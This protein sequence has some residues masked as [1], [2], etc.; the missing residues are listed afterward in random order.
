MKR[1]ESGQLIYS[2]SDLIRFINSPFASWMDRYHLEN[3]LVLTPDPESEDQKL[4]AETGIAHEQ[5][6]LAEFEAGPLPLAKISIESW[7]QA[8]ED[9]LS[10]L[11]Q[12][13]P[14]IYQAALSKDNFSGFADFLVL[15]EDNNYEIWDT[16]LA[17]SPKPYFIIQL[18]CYSE[19]LATTLNTELPKQ[20]GVILGTNER[21]TFRLEDFYYYYCAIKLEF[22]K[23]QDTFDGNIEN[24]P[25]PMPRSDH[26]RW[27]SHAETYFESTDHLVQVAGIS[28]G[29][30]K[31]LRR[32]DIHTMA[33]LATFDGQSI[34]KLAKETL[35]KLVTQA[36]L[37]CQTRDARSTD[38]SIPP[39]FLILEPKGPNGEIVGLGR[40]PAEHPADVYFDMEGYPLEVGGL[41]YLFGAWVTNDGTEPFKD[42]WAH[43]RAEEKQAFEGFIDWVYDRWRQ[44]P[45]MH[46]YH[47]AAYE[48]SAVRRLSTRHDTRQD[49]VDDLLRNN[50]FVDLY[51]IVRKGLMIGEDSYSIK[52]VERL[53]RPKRKTEVANAVDSIVQY[54]RWQASGQEK[55]WTKSEILK[56]I[57]D[58]NE[59]DCK[60]TAELYDWLKNIAHQ[61]GIPIATAKEIA[62]I[63]IPE[64]VTARLELRNSLREYGDELGPVLGD[65]IEF[66]R[67]EDKPKWWKFFDRIETT[68]EELRDDAA[69]IAQIE[70]VGNTTPEKQ[71]LLQSY[72]FDP[73][74]ECKSKAGDKVYFA[75]VPE[76]TF[77]LFSIDASEG[78]LQLKA[79]QRTLDASYGGSFPQFGSLIPYEIVS[80]NPIPTALSEVAS[81]H[82]RGEL[83]SACSSI[84]GRKSSASEFT[85]L[86]HENLVE[87]AKS[88]AKSM[89]GGCFVVQGPPGTGKTFTASHMIIDLVLAGKKVGIAS[90]SHKAILNLMS[91]C[92]ERAKEIS[93][94]LT[95]IKVGGDESDAIFEA[96]PEI[97]Y[98]KDIKAGASA[99]IS[100]I[101]G[102]TAWAFSNELMRD[103]VDYLVIDEAGQV[104][105]ANAVAMSSATENLILLG[106][107]M[108]LEQPIQGSHPGH[109]G[110]SALQYALLDVGRS[111]IDN[112]VFHAVVPIHLGLFL[113]ES[114][115]MHS[116]VC[117]FISDSIYEGQLG[118]HPDCDNQ[119]I[120]IPTGS[121][122]TRPH[123]ITFLPIEHEGNVQKSEEEVEQVLR[124]YDALVGCQYVDKAGKARALGLDDFL[125]ISP[126]NA[127]VR[128]LTDALPMGARVGSVD[129]FQG[130]EAPICIVSMCSSFGEY[131]SRGLKF[132]LDRNRVNVAIS[133]AQCLAIIIG[134][135]RTAYADASSI[136]EMKLINLYS[137]LVLDHSPQSV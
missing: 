29:Q 128:A 9:T 48:V 100:G 31:K 135:P 28:V 68:D 5:A 64:E 93:F 114:R 53:Y 124:V 56:D 115:R 19:M 10:I 107:Q 21:I 109:A 112:P 60:S 125:F 22:L 132:I 6:I 123:G 116:S 121:I 40:L 43:D 103:S 71:S 38:P 77:E 80:A 55:L 108:Q 8:S 50:V 65:L 87:K 91:A 86:V 54:A 49:E 58:Y 119:G 133:R 46:I 14:V 81:G 90:N 79:T 32:A 45:G 73:S 82:L 35:A 106:D 118:A 25:E 30:I 44:N 105:L 34:P 33:E 13:V 1:L 23:L 75:H 11:N 122:V 85:S 74:Q 69:C 15:N 24:R 18:C 110:L 111:T 99:F 95:A 42:W 78:S 57:R 62:T 59:D 66:H 117:K 94:S 7:Q 76:K 134:D 61:H 113:G 92:A 52:R 36:K 120:A 126:Y 17:R 89:N 137:K 70:A 102:G 2:A 26:G 72:R 27:S 136:D 51:T 67:R 104:S 4:I 47:Y 37:Q 3:P 63:E 16:K 41:E 98:A 97:K 130:Q 39:T 20:F 88:I 101:I 127:Q 131:G 83:K 96:Y 12:K 129:K 84:L